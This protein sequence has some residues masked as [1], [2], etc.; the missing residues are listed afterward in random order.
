MV[1]EIRQA[2]RLWIADFYMRA[3]YQATVDGAR[4]LFPNNL[5]TPELE[6]TLVDRYSV[7]APF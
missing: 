2:M 6:K 1:E 3:K 7:L 4:E 5:M